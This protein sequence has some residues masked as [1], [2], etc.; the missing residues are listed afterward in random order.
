MHRPQRLRQAI[1]FNLLKYALSRM[2]RRE[3]AVVGRMPILRGDHQ[4]ERRLESVYD[5]DDL[6][7]LRHGE[8]AAGQEVVLNINQNQCFHGN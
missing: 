5:R 2:A 8:R 7:A 1:Q 6:V 3:A 4:R